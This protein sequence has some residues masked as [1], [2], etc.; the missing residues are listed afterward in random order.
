MQ[1]LNIGSTLQ[2][3][4][5]RIE[6]V[7]GQ[8]G[9]GITYVAEQK[10]VIQGPLG[11]IETSFK[12]AIK[13]FFMKSVCNREENTLEVSIPSSGSLELA[14][15]FRQKFIKE[16]MNLSKLN[17]PNI[18]KVLD[19]FEENGTAYYVM[20]Y[21]EGGSLNDFVKEKGKLLEQEALAYIQ[22]IANALAY[23]HEQRMNHLDV[24]PANILL[25]PNGDVV[26]ID[27][28]LSKCYDSAGEQTSTT[29]VG[30]SVGYAPIEQSKVG[31]VGSFSPAT[32]IYSLGATL[33]KLVTGITP[34]DASEVFDE[35]LPD[36]PDVSD[37]VQSV[38]KT[39]M[40]PRRV[41]RPQSIAVLLNLLGLDLIATVEE[42]PVK[43]HV[44]IAKMEKPKPVIEVVEET[45]ML[46]QE[47]EAFMR[48]Y[49]VDFSQNHPVD[50]GLSVL[51]SNG[52]LG[53]TTAVG[54]GELY[55]WGDA[56][57]FQ[58]SQ[59]KNDYLTSTDIKNITNTEHDICHVKMK[60]NWRMPTIMEWKELKD[61]C[62]WKRIKEN[63]IE[64]YIVTGKTGKSIFLPMAGRRYGKE[65][66][67]TDC[68]YYWSASNMTVIAENAYYFF[69]TKQTVTVT[70]API[71][72]G[73]SV[74]AVMDK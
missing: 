28:G 57:G 17:H 1:H 15:K 38:I 11:A 59:D 66:V 7:L 53:A 44:P 3:G 35:G 8:G 74:R 72:V 45:I 60:G 16:A 65:I 30:I 21:V 51:W 6:K 25:R 36:M 55:A 43:I 27:F 10:V 40:Q 71:W 54:K 61:G 23:L 9:F 47:E 2:S 14:L 32:D 12:V 13:E 73:R 58:S 37:K 67:C 42:K 19:V 22:K 24:K 18:I 46:N 5:Y 56:T 20:E 41:E 49:E 29:P 63:D 62:I 26:L 48:K 31:G 39:A 68:G 33:F 64:G 52:N 34:P 70:H 4:K 50:L 69:I